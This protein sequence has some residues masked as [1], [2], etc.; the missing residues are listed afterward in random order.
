[1]QQVTRENKSCSK[2]KKVVETRKVA[3]KL[4]SN[5]WKALV[6]SWGGRRILNE[7]Q[8]QTS[9]EIFQRNEKSKIVQLMLN[10]KTSHLSNTKV[11]KKSNTVGKSKREN[12]GTPNGS[13]R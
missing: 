6:Q 3:K 4:P 1:M 13:F 9:K 2:G 12:L 5:L 10:K 7:Q 8:K 11:Q